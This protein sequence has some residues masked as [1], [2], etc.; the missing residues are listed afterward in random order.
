MKEEN[1]KSLQK[2]IENKSPS[3][4]TK[5]ET[6]AYNKSVNEYNAMV[7]DFNTK[8]ELLNKQRSGIY[9]GW[10][11]EATRFVDKHVP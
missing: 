7:K 9:N 1:L 4:R 10:D 3:K 11:N 6:D 2:A 8:G 5:E